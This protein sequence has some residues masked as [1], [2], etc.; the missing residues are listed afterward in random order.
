VI[1]V[2]VGAQMPFDRLVQ[3]MDAWAARV[4]RRDVFAQI[5]ATRLR[6]R[7]IEFTDFL[8]A[9]QFR[10]RVASASLVVAHA[11]MGSILTALEMGKPILVLPRRAD[12]LETRNDHQLAT[13]TRFE[14]QGRIAVAYD[15]DQLQAKLDNLAMLRPSAPIA[16]HASLELLEA[17]RTFVHCPP[18]LQKT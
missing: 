13:A 12:L 14:A 18:M 9:D 11:G 2:T 15:V 5:G 8:D 6:P 17:I 16:S 4:G 7:N 3:A 1:F 10:A